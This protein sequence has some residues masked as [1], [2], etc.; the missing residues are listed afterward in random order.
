MNMMITLLTMT[1]LLSGSFPSVQHPRKPDLILAHIT[2][3]LESPEKVGDNYIAVS[4]EARPTH[5]EFSIRIENVGR[6]DFT[7]PFYLSWTDN[8]QELRT[9]VYSHGQVINR[10]GKLLSSGGFLDARINGPLYSVRTTVRFK[11]QSGGTSISRVTIP[12]IDETYS[13]NN[14]YDLIV[15]VQ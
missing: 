2:Y 14:S 5:G 13:D 7:G 12:S 11:I 3:S 1:T 15:E 10:E 8:V 4:S 9:G 6:Q